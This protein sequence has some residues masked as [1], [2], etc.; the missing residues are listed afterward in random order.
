M[1]LI[2]VA[3]GTE[4]EFGQDEPFRR[5]DRRLGNRLES[6]DGTAVE[7]LQ[8]RGDRLQLRFAQVVQPAPAELAPRRYFRSLE[9]GDEVPTRTDGTLLDASTYE[10]LP[11]EQKGSVRYFS[12]EGGEAVL[13]EVDRDTW[14]TLAAEV[15]GTV[16]YF[17]IVGGLGD[18]SPFDT[19]GDSLTAV[20]YAQLPAGEQ[21]QILGAGRLIRLR[22]TGAVFLHGTELSVAARRGGPDMPW[23]LGEAGNVTELTPGR[24]MVVSALGARGVIRDL[25]VTPNPFTPNG[26]GINDAASIGL[27][28]F[29]IFEPRPLTLKVFTLDGRLV[30]RLEQMAAGGRRAFE[31]DGS[32]QHGKQ[33]APGLYLVKVESEVDNSR[34]ADQAAIRVIGVVY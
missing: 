9:E 4:A 8:D 30:R 13:E 19:L 24:D 10:S 17:R 5:Y 21:G 7:V 23:Q 3:V 22:F 34:I 18:Q 25:T 32:D 26:D 28:L 16:R 12:L 15:R 14:E 2:D 31:W 27:S 33:V 20:E 1:E 29:R 11:E 6:A